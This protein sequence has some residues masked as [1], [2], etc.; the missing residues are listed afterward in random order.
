MNIINPATEEIITTIQED[1]KAFLALKFER[2]Q[3]SAKQWSA[4]PIQKR[5]EILEKFVSLLKE[6]MEELAAILTSEMGKPLQQSRNEINGAGGKALWLAQHATQ[7]LSEEIMSVSDQMTEKIVHEPLGIICNISAWNYPYNVGVNIFVPALLAGN[8]VM[9]KP[10]EY[11]TLTGLQIGK[12]LVEAGV[13]AD[14]FQLAIGEGE[15]GRALLDMPF[16]GYYFTG[17]YQTGQKI[18]EHVSKKMVPCILEL[19]GKDPVYVAD[20]VVDVAGAAAGIAD[21]AFYNNGQSCCSVERIYVQSAIYDVFVEAFVAEVRSWKMGS[22]TED[23]VY[24]TVLSRRAQLDV[25]ESQ[26]ADAVAKGAQVLVG[27]KRI[28]RKGNYFEPTVLVNV[29]NE[30]AVMREES[31]GPIIGIMRVENDAEAV[32]LMND[33]SYGLTAGVY[34]AGQ[35]RAEA[36]LAQINAGSGY[37]NC[38]DR[39]SAALPWSGRGHSGFGSTLS[40]VGL[41]NFTKP[42]AYHLRK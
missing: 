5:A 16:D 2:L 42:K 15:V 6:N 14:V 23:G 17:S 11:A 31:F 39:V 20:D 26:V 32:A 22:P 25:L 27:G 34:S 41:R 37:W 12:Y 19:G 7:Y 40:Q 1:D 13:P 33:T 8:A 35:Q 3:K 30:M 10:S 24:I 9:Y 38:C 36:I 29:T 28:D 21:G 18:Y 4:V